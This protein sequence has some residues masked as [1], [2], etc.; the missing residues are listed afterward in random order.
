MAE[1]EEAAGERGG[2]GQ[3]EIKGGLGRERTRIA[4][5][6]PPA[7]PGGCA[8]PALRFGRFAVTV[9][10]PASGGKADSLSPQAGRVLF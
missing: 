3:V 9:S 1:A 7:P 4:A 2:K 6:L 5:A 10:N 8:A